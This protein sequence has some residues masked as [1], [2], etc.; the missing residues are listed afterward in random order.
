MDSAL[1]GELGERLVEQVHYALVELVKNSYDADASHVTVKFIENDS[2]ISEIHIID[3]GIGMNF[4]EVQD[5]WMHIAT[6]NKLNK[7]VSQEYGRP[8]TGSKG[9][10]RF[11]CRR[12]GKKLTL[13]TTG[14]NRNKFERTEV[15]FNWMEFRP[16]TKVTDIQCDGNQETQKTGETG[17]ILIISDL[18][19]EWSTTG[20]N[21][22]KRQLAVLAANR[23][24]RR[25][26][27]E[28]DPGFNISLEAPGFEGDIRDLRSDLIKA[29]WGTLKAYIN[30]GHKAV[31]ELDALG[32]GK[33][34]IVSE[35]K[36]SK[37]SD[38]GLGIG[39]MVLDRSQMRDTS[40]VSIGNLQEI[41]PEWGGVQ[42]RYKGFRVYPY[43]DDDWL[44]IDEDRGVRKGAPSKELQTFADTL[45]GVDS[46]RA[47]LSLLSMR[48]HIGTVEIGPVAKGFVM[49]ANR[50]GFLDSDEFKELRNFVR[51]A[52]NWATIYRDFYI[53]EQTRGEAEASRVSFQE[54]IEQPVE[55]HTV[56]E[57]AVNYLEKEF[58]DIASTLPTKQRQGI[59]TTFYKAT[60]AIVKHNQSNKEELKHLRLIASTST[61][62]LIFSHEVK[63]LL[64]HL[65]SSLLQ[66]ENIKERLA[67]TER[68]HI[69][70]IQD[71]LRNSKERLLELLDM[72]A[73]IG[74]DSRK[75]SPKSLALHDRVEGARNAFKVI[76]ESYGITL[77]TDEIP[78]N[79]VVGPILE[80][81][82]YAVLL[83]LLSNS[84]KSIIAA[85]NKRRIKISAKKSGG[86]VYIRFMDTGLGLNPNKHRDI[87]IP[88]VADIDG[89]LYSILEKKLNPEDKYIV[90]TGSGLGLS[91]V[92][93]ILQAR[94]GDIRILP[95]EGDW[96]AVLEVELP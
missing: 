12:L 22:L 92:K 59:S 68:K 49:K 96:K 20:Y 32:I 37:L 15:T 91:I 4:I 81:E 23:G 41:L 43:G 50:E 74:V 2:G 9:I 60:D 86:R 8:K 69:D 57:T 80:A 24:A 10:G 71:W 84:I 73:L 6:T 87:F 27:F 88:F 82:L 51:F 66:L 7:D 78:S 42:I 16:G 28:E 19:D 62:I 38:I 56:I 77:N 46:S 67:R 72:T 63:M 75:E 17:T 44:K 95:P 85:D 52:I 3:D 54:F 48:N 31:C 33:K 79:I 39:I 94:N 58:R 53:R 90:G 29:G 70:D 36:F 61:L 76:A 25:P 1:L 64:G 89:K 14:K 34:T 13:I 21:Y 30:K 45:R 26:D 47:L 35:G 55:S 83:N 40:I 11:C 5:Y 93:E 18:I 65:E